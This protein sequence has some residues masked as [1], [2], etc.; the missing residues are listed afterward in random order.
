MSKHTQ[1]SVKEVR[2]SAR[3]IVILVNMAPANSIYKPVF[4]KYSTIKFLRVAKIPVQ[5]KE[6]SLTQK[7]QEWSSLASTFKIWTDDSTMEI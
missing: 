1:Y 2:E 5:I 3:N 6:D 7:M 4:N